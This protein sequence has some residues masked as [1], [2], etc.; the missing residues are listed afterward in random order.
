M[1]IGREKNN[2]L[3]SLT[4]INV[5]LLSV[6]H[7]YN[8][9]VLILSALLM[10]S[11]I[12]V[13]SREGKFLPLMLFYLPWSPLLKIS[14][15]TFTWFTLVTP[16]FF[17]VM[18]FRNKKIKIGKSPLIVVLF[19]IT[20]T[21]FVKLINGFSIGTSYIYF[22]FLLFFIPVYVINFWR[23]ISYITCVLYMVLGVLSACV[24]S[25]LLIDNPQMAGFISVYEWEA[26][27][28]TRFS[29]FYGDANFY[30]AQIVIA[31]VGI[32]TLLVKT[33]KKRVVFLQIVTI[34][35]LILFGLLSVSKMFLLST[36]TLIF[37]GVISFLFQKNKISNKFFVLIFIL[38]IGLYIL[39]SGLFSNE[40]KQYTF[41][42]TH[43]S[44]TTGRADLQE[45]YINYLL[46]HPVNLF[47]GVGITD[48]FVNSR[49]SHN[50]FLQIIWQIGLCGILL[51]VS[52]IR[53]TFS[54]IKLKTMEI[55]ERSLFIFLLPIAYM[56]PWIALDYLFF[57]EFFYYML[58]TVLGM[59]YLKSE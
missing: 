29:G 49:A 32:F 24:A 9:K 34:L 5:V 44:L 14:P 58:F 27:G 11:L 15:G 17:I 23:S 42:F 55:S 1:I 28:L 25:T 46:S 43:G 40:I 21:L 10:F 3:L 2:V 37:I 26:A 6:S 12:L 57:D 18:M 19:F 41:R 36:G 56:L 48:V 31:I 16:L 52:W 4:L 33:L 59:K 47:L 38:I 35:V 50:T 13:F 22:I 20:Y 30:S 39:Y 53:I 51:L 7:A 54:P 45:T 8:N